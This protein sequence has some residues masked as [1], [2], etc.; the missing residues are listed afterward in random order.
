M[1]DS[2]NHHH[3]DGRGHSHDHNGNHH[4]GDNHAD[5]HAE[6]QAAQD[7]FEHY[8]S[9]LYSFAGYNMYSQV[10][11][12]RQERFFNSLSAAHKV[13]LLVQILWRAK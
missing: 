3:H 13:R 7:E 5:M 11:A 8:K 6:E 12:S 2:H 10:W 9:I 4:H 1:S